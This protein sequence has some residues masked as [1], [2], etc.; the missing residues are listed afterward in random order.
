M[1]IFFTQVC[2]LATVLLFAQKTSTI[3]ITQETAN[4]PLMLANLNTAQITSG[5]LLD[6]V[7]DFAYNNKRRFIQNRVLDST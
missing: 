6:K 5:V 3:N 1:K 7:T 4:W 2:L